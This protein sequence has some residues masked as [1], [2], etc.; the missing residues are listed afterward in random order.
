MGKCEVC[1]REF[2]FT[3]VLTLLPDRHDDCHRNM[4]RILDRQTKDY[5]ELLKDVRQECAKQSHYAKLLNQYDGG[6]RIGFKDADAWLARLEE[7]KEAQTNERQPTQKRN[8]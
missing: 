7:L 5:A 6:E 2:T 1:G 3:D 4:V 8:P